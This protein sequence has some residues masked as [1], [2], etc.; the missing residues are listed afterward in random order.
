ML[1]SRLYYRILPKYKGR[2]ISSLFGLITL[3]SNALFTLN[4][5]VAFRIPIEYAE[6]VMINPEKIKLNFGQ[7]FEIK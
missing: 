3:R 6:P 5:M 2:K 4:E 1:V 7:R